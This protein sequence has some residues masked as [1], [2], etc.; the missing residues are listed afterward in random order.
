[1]ALRVAKSPSES[2]WGRIIA[3]QRAAWFAAPEL[4]LQLRHALRC[5]LG[6]LPLIDFAEGAED[7]AAKPH[8]SRSG[9][10]LTLACD[11]MAGAL[12]MARTASAW[13]GGRFLSA[14]RLA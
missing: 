11:D 9:L 12:A 5:R 6:P 14:A 7:G 1:V 2:L 10:L 8:R 3:R 13:S 4:I